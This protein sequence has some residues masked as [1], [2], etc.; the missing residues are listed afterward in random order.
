[1]LRIT[2]A[3]REEIPVVHRIMLAAFE[4][5]RGVLDPPSG[6]LSETVEDIIRKITPDGGAVIA[7]YAD[8]PVGSARYLLHPGY[9]YIGRVSVLPQHRGFGAGSA[10]LQYLEQLALDGQLEETRV[11]VR[12][13]LPANVAYYRK[14]RYEVIEEHEYPSQTDRYY[15][16]SKRLR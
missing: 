13:S 11:G 8:E 15:I 5:Y 10:L 1:M 2:H 16:M 3:S 6:A 9:L 12:L 14:L 4:E 7:W